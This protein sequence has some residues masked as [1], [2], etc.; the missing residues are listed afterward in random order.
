MTYQQVTY[1]ILDCILPRYPLSLPP[2]YTH[3]SN[4]N[5]RHQLTT[6]VLGYTS[7][8]NNNRLDYYRPI[9]RCGT[10]LVLKAERPR[11]VTPFPVCI[12]NLN[13]TLNHVSAFILLLLCL[14]IAYLNLKFSLHSAPNHTACA[15]LSTLQSAIYKFAKA[16]MSLAHPSG[17]LFMVL[18]DRE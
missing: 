4:R 8:N 3:N 7:I 15:N 12:H 5:I 2:L 10:S 11:T 16:Q 14:A 17:C 18:T 13:L 1:L 6:L 9:K